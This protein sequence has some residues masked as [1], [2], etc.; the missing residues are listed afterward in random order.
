MGQ[1]NCSISGVMEQACLPFPP[2]ERT[3]PVLTT[4][5]LVFLA[6]PG[7]CNFCSILL[8]RAVFILSHDS[9]VFHFSAGLW[10]G[11]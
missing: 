8:L 10:D 3:S 11:P 1:G 5:F 7:L 9:S 4:G 2:G 6:A